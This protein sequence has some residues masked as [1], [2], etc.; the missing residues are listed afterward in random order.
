MV[1]EIKEYANIEEFIRYLD[2]EIENLRNNLGEL[3]KVVE[4][5]RAEAEKARKLRETLSKIVGG[6]EKIGS[7]EVD[8][9]DIKLLVNPTVEDEATLM[10]D[11]VADVQERIL[12]FQK[13][14]KA[15][16]PLVELGELPAKVRVVF[17][18]GKP[19][20]LIIK[21]T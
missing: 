4:D 19:I 13:V 8:L 16:E 17:K 11:L 3:L 15:V 21:T 9:K 7:K 1:L 6:L 12:S 14:R 10:E 5:L 2:K 18:D 20:K